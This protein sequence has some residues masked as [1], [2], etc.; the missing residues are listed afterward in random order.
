MTA[1]QLETR[2]EKKVS[3]LEVKKVGRRLGDREFLFE[4]LRKVCSPFLYSAL[5]VISNFDKWLLI[6]MLFSHQ[7]APKHFFCLLPLQLE[8]PDKLA[9]SFLSIIIIPLIH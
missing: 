6:M 1:A 3:A 4:V 8:V 2:E 9:S 5:L 7:D